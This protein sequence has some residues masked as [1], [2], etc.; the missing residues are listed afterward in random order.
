ISP[1]CTGNNRAAMTQVRSVRRKGSGALRLRLGRCLC[2]YSLR[3]Q[4]MQHSVNP[5]L[6]NLDFKIEPMR[7]QIPMRK[8]CIAVAFSVPKKPIQWEVYRPIK[9]SPGA[10]IGIV[11]APDETSAL[12]TAI[13]EFG[14]INPVH[15][16]RVFVR[17]VPGDDD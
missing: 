15:Q 1:S 9:G 10:F 17:R 5:A 8:L 4:T 16:N 12:K 11:E 6:H 14:I 13:E 3:S 2:A 7:V